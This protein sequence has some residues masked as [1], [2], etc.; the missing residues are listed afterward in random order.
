M[1]QWS[2]GG[3]RT[4]FLPPGSQS[5]ASEADLE[6]STRTSEG[7]SEL[8]SGSV[9]GLQHADLPPVVEPGPVSRGRSSMLY[10]QVVILAA[11][12]MLGYYCE[13]T[14]TFSPA[15]PDPGPEQGSRVQ[16][17]T[18]C[19]V[20]GAGLLLQYNSNHL[21]DQE[22]VL[23]LGD[24]CYVNPMMRRTFRF[25]GNLK[26]FVNAGQLVTGSLTPYFLSVCRPNYTALGCQDTAQFIVQSDACTGDPDDIARARKTFPSKE[27][28]LSLY[29]AVYL[30]MYVMTCV[31][32]RGGRLAGPLVSLSLVSVAV[33][34]GV[35]R[36]TEYR[37]HWR[38]V[39][40]GQAIGAPSLSF[41]S[42]VLHSPG[43]GAVQAALATS[44]NK[45]IVGL[46]HH[47]HCVSAP[48]EVPGD[49]DHL[50]SFSVF[51]EGE[52][53]RSRRTSEVLH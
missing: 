26:I 13:F 16:P 53:A 41:W 15:Q 36:V 29:L 35:N 50:Y 34:T 51:A 11:A 37:N 52:E 28:A 39:L 45:G 24:C 42:C 48:P 20:V 38:D 47:G 9:L 1:A 22:K 33:L 18:L 31:G 40:A 49:V 32:S 43:E 8:A 12:L 44:V 30:A 7:N 25:L 46:F 17:V 10:F 6:D 14:D 21:Y 3:G 4:R 27:A 19:C 23:V 2:R 5:G